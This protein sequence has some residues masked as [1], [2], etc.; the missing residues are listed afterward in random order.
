M[1]V[2]VG[3]QLSGKVD[4]TA[5]VLQGEILSPL[6]FILYLPDMED[7][8][9]G[10]DLRDLNLNGNKDIMMMLYANDL[11]ILADTP[12]ELKRK[13]KALEDFCSI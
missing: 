8:F 12:A 4:I 11:A 5:G 1:Q 6:R 9:R 10:R 7:F 13:L 3:R 2:R